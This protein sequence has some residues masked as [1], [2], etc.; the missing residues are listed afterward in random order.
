MK[1]E[2]YDPLNGGAGA[3][4][5]AHANNENNTEINTTPE[6]MS[7]GLFPL[8]ALGVT[9]EAMG[10][11]ICTTERTPNA[12]AGCCLLGIL[13][14]SLG[15]GLQV[16]SGPNRF[17]RAGLYLL[18]SAESGCGKSETFRHIARRFFELERKM[19]KAWEIG[20]LPRIAAELE[21]TE[22][23]IGKLKG[24]AGK[25][26]GQ[27]RKD[28][29]REL[30]DKKAEVQSLK[31][32]LTPPTLTCE[33]V[34]VERLAILLAA[35][36]EQ[37]ASLSSD[38][39][40]VVDNIM[41][42][43]RDGKGT[44]ESIYLK[45][46]SGDSV[47]VDRVSRE[48]ISLTSPC[49]TVL[50]L[51]QPDK[52]ETI[53]SSASLNE[54]GFL[55]RLLVCHTNCQP[56]EIGG[57]SPPRIPAEVSGAYDALIEELLTTYRL[58]DCPALIRPKPEAEQA[59]IKHH[60][61]LI[62]R[63]RV[64]GDICDVQSYAARWTE[65]AWRIA[66]CLHAAK[67]GVNAASNSL[68]LETAQRAIRLA[69][70]F[71]RQQLEILSAGRENTKQEKRDKVLSLLADHPTGIT[72]RDVLN[73]RIERTAYACRALLDELEK[74]GILEG[75]EERPER[76]GWGTRIYTRRKQ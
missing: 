30:Q 33:D 49:I 46:Y 39:R 6:E 13:S 8:D 38:A 70:W 62:P 12:L 4:T 74:A 67:H 28:A 36:G 45:A 58:A 20:E 34:T 1:I 55:P 65:Q 43:Y 16:Q 48:P 69:D 41:G 73:K 53:L 42:R 3:G 57:F 26:E 76:G 44:D 22:A 14:A 24:K 56:Q 21:F 11:A 66:V 52:L 9:L 18:P 72:T 5:Q 54:G 50:W 27:A 64:G 60:D 35:N 2:P 37:I 31:K 63:R 15:A 68:D 59:L 25:L 47:R 7:Q 71:S 19:L 17:T 40:G 75:R 23:E 32:K 51:I 10:R 29:L 61:E